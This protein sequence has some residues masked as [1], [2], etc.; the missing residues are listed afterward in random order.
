MQQLILII[1]LFCCS[2]VSC[3]QKVGCDALEL[4]DGQYVLKNSSEPFSGSVECFFEDGALNY[5]S[6]YENGAQTGFWIEYDR[7]GSEVASGEFLSAADMNGFDKEL[8]EA[9]GAEHATISHWKEGDFNFLTITLIAEKLDTTDLRN[10]AWSAQYSVDIGM[11]ILR[12]VTVNHIWNSKEVIMD[13]SLNE[14]FLE[15]KE[16]W[17]QDSLEF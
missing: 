14:D 5:E 4:K 11:N 1:S 15:P 13:L 10:L 7:A 12:G 3:N 6:N 8:A 2:L 17:E 9:T 16:I